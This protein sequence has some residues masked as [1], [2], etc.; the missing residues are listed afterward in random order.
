MYKKQLISTVTNISN[1][2][3]LS[4]RLY[5]TTNEH[6]TAYGILV[7]YNDENTAYSREVDEI[8]KSRESAENLLSKFSRAYVTPHSLADFI[9]DSMT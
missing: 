4:Y 6:Q 7:L 8:T 2:V 5:E 9:Q 3:M 1:N